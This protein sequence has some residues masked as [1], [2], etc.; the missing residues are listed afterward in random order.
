MCFEFVTCECNLSADAQSGHIHLHMVDGVSSLHRPPVE[1]KFNSG[2]FVGE[3]GTDSNIFLN[4]LCSSLM[5]SS[6][7]SEWEPWKATAASL[8]KGFEFAKFS[9][10]AGV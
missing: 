10:Y 3:W 4:S 6:S 1:M 2:A 8:F 9:P 5:N 7:F